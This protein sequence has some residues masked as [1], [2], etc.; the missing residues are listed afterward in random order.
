MVRSDR[1]NPSLA[2]AITRYHDRPYPTDTGKQPVA[3][4]NY[5][6]EKRQR[7]LAKKQKKADKESRKAP[8]ADAPDEAPAASELPETPEANDTPAQ[9]E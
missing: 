5:S 9:P 1:E 2:L 3:K 6:F 4:P 7:E 8:A